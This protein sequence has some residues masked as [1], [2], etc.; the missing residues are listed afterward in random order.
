MCR[1]GCVVEGV[2]KEMRVV[3][4]QCI[5]GCVLL[6]VSGGLSIVMSTLGRVE[7]GRE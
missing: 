2:C 3:V 4:M 1:K 7:C 6:R 5:E